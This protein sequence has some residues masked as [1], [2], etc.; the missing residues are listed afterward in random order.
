M[1][2]IDFLLQG[3]LAAAQKSAKNSTFARIMDSAMFAHGMNMGEAIW[4]AKLLKKEITMKQFMA[5]EKSS[6]ILAG[7]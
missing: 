3:D 2:A 7:A 5:D 1:R 6:I 4:V